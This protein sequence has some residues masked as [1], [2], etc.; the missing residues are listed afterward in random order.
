M[1]SFLKEIDNKKATSLDKIPSKLLKMA[2]SI[3]VPSLTAIFSN[4]ILTGI[5]PNQWKSAKVT[6]IFKKGLKSDSTNYRPISVIPIDK[7]LKFFEQ[8]IYNQLY[9]Y[10]NDNKL[11]SSCQSGFRSLHSILTALLE[12][13][14]NWSVDIDNGLLNGVV[15]IDLTKAFDNIDHEIILRKSHSWVLTRQLSGGSC[16]F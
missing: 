14:N 8:I 11:L 13:T 2:A 5:Y 15:F 6:P 4:S 3:I 16:R 1:L 10:L 7:F 12:A 9:H